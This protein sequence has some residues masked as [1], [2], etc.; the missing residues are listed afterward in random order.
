MRYMVY[1]G[2][3]NPVESFEADTRDEVEETA[4]ELAVQWLAESY[5]CEEIEEEEV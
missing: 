5:W 1:A 4:W 3:G 2:V